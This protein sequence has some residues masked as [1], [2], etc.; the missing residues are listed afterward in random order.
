MY[1]C[2][3]HHLLPV[4]RARP[5]WPTSPTTTA[6][7]PGCR[8]WPGSS[9]PTPSGPRCRSGSPSQ[10][11]DEIE[12]TLQPE[13]RAGG[14]RGRAP[15]HVDAR[16]A[17][18]RLHHRHL[19]GAG[20]VPRRRGDPRRGHAVRP[21]SADRR[22][23][24]DPSRTAR[25][26]LG[27]RLPSSVFPL[28]MGVVNVTPDSFS[29]GGC[30]ARP[31]AMPSPTPWRWSRRVPTSSTSAASPPGPAP[32]PSPFDEELRRVV[33]VVEAL[34]GHVRVSI[35]TMQAG[36]RRGGGRRRAPPSSTTCR[37]RSTWPRWP[38][39]HGVGWV[40][41]AHAGLDPRTMQHRPEL[42]RRG[43]RGHR[44]SSPSRAPR[45]A[46]S[47]SARSGSTP[48]SASARPRPTT[49][50]CS[51]TCRRLVDTGFP[52]LVGT[53]RKSLPRAPARRGRRRRPHADAGRRPP[54]GLHRH[55]RV[56]AAPRRRDGARARRRR[57][58][59]RPS[60]A[61]VAGSGGGPGVT[62]LID[63]EATGGPAAPAGRETDRWQ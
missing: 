42:R 22:P 8:S 1:S 9:T 57:D 15:V 30:F 59:D 63:N 35:D 12:R 24:P 6:G 4:H 47:G 34:A 48:A 56:G 61:A 53:S 38:P 41:H 5:T 18:A 27:S 16:R 54:R 13:G 58:R 62:H 2:C 44:P 50:P 19:G 7:S 43:H 39:T 11:A 60:G 28:V 31:P 32:S 3:E 10:V 51:P 46:T 52:V 23:G 55:R 14:H 37:P 29:D 49:W 20:P 36:R 21:G 40:A 45:R 17:Q 33:P 26:D 25:F